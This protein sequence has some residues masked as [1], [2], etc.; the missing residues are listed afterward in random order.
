MYEKLS[1][2]T[3]TA[4]TEAEEFHK[5]Y[6]LEVVQIPTN[7]PMVRNDMPDQVYKNEQGKFLALTK[8]IKELHDSGRPILITISATSGKA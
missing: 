2:M 8:T 7:K 3:G 5:I 4:A 1:G 6:N